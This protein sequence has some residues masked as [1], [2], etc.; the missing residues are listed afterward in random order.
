MSVVNV[1]DIQYIQ[2]ENNQTIKPKRN[3]RWLWI[4]VAL[5]VLAFLCS[6]VTV[7]AVI[8][9]F[10]ITSVGATIYSYFT[11]GSGTYTLFSVGGYSTNEAS[12]SLAQTIL[13]IFAI[14]FVIFYGLRSL[15]QSVG[16]EGFVKTML[17]FV[18]GSVMLGAIVIILSQLT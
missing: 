4:G 9:G 15:A 6:T 5:G 1:T 17:V 8:T 13:P 7:L 10:N 18:V 16:F 11:V 12:N 3:K 14:M 2:N